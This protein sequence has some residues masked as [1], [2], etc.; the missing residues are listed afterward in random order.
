M[1]TSI[2]DA[3]RHFEDEERPERP[4]PPPFDPEAVA[5]PTR[6]PAARR[7]APEEIAA[8]Q[9]RLHDVLS[10]PEPGA[11]KV[12]AKGL[13]R[14]GMQMLMG[15][16]SAV[17]WFGDLIS[18]EDI[19]RGGYNFRK[20]WEERVR[21]GWSAP[22]P[23]I[24]KGT[25]GEN[26]SVKRALGIISEGVGSLG[27]A[28][29]A[30]VV[31][32]Q[33]WA[34]PVLLGVTETAGQYEEARAKGRDF[35]DASGLF[36]IAAGGTIWLESLPIGRM[37]KGF[38]KF[39]GRFP[40]G[41]TK[42][43]VGT[44][45]QE[46][47]QE[48]AQQLLQNAVAKYGYDDTRSLMEGMA[49]ATIGGFGAGGIAGGTIGRLQ[50]FAEKHG[51]KEG[52][53]ED[54]ER[55]KGAMERE[56]VAVADHM[57]GEPDTGSVVSRLAD[58]F[59]QGHLPTEA[60]IAQRGDLEV[61]QLVTTPKGQG[62]INEID[63][64]YVAVQLHGQTEPEGF[65]DEVIMP[66]E[67]IFPG[68]GEEQLEL[69]PEP[70]PTEEAAREM[71]E[72]E[73]K[74]AK[75]E[76]IGYVRWDEDQQVW[77]WGNRRLGVEG[78]VPL[79]QFKDHP[80]LGTAKQQAKL[81]ARAL[82]TT[83]YHEPRKE[84]AKPVPKPAEPG[85]KVEADK[86]EPQRTAG[87]RND[88]FFSGEWAT[89]QLETIEQ[90]KH[91][92]E[93]AAVNTEA[94]LKS[95][96]YD[97]TYPVPEQGGIL[98]ARRT[99]KYKTDEAYRNKVE[100]VIQD[101]AQVSLDAIK[102]RQI[103]TGQVN[104][105]LF[106]VAY[107]LED[108][109]Y[110]QTGKKSTA[111]AS[112]NVSRAWSQ[113][114]KNKYP[115]V[116]RLGDIS[117]REALQNSLDA[118]MRAKRTKKLVGQKGAIDIEV[119][120]REPIPATPGADIALAN[121]F[122][123]LAQEKG[124]TLSVDEAYVQLTDMAKYGSASKHA[125][126]MKPP[127]EYLGVTMQ[128]VKEA[129]GEG[130]T[131]S[132]SGFSVDD[133]GIGMSSTDIDTKLLDLHGTGKDVEGEF[134]GFG[135][136]GAVIFGPHKSARWAL[137]T[138]DNY[139]T[140]QMA[141][142]EEEVGTTELRQGTRI[143]VRTDTAIVHSR[144]ARMY[145]E[146]TRPPTGVKIRYR[147]QWDGSLR[148]L[149]DPFKGRRKKSHHIVQDENTEMEVSYYPKPHEDYERMMVIRLVG[150]TA[151]TK[152]TQAIRKVEDEGFR[153]ALVIDITTKVTPSHLDYP[154]DA[155]RMNFKSGVPQEAVTK[156]INR[157]TTDKASAARVGVLHTWH[158][159][160]A[161]R[162]WKDTL[163]K[164][165]T[166]KRY[167]ALLKVIDEIYQETNQWYGRGPAI[168]DSP[169]T[170]L[171]LMR[172]KID[173]GV[174]NRGGSQLHA[175]FLTA[176]EAAAWILAEPLGNPNP[177][178]Y[179]L[180]SKKKD[181]K[182]VGAEYAALTG[183]MG[184]NFRTQLDKT[185]LKSPNDFAHFLKSL[186]AHEYAHLE[187][188]PHDEMFS[189]AREH[190]DRLAA[191]HFN[192]LLRISE[193]MIGRDS[194]MRTKVIVKKEV[195]HVVERVIEEERVVE[196]RIETIVAD[197][198]QMELFQ[199]HELGG[200]GGSEAEIYLH[201]QS[202]RQLQLFASGNDR[203]A[204]GWGS[205][206]RTLEP[207]GGIQQPS[208]QGA[209]RPS[210]GRLRHRRHDATASGV[211][212]ADFP[213]I[214]FGPPEQRTL[215]RRVRNWITP[216]TAAQRRRI[217]EAPEYP[218]QMSPPW[219]RALKNTPQYSIQRVE[220]PVVTHY[221]KK[222][223]EPVTT[224][225]V[226][227][228][229]IPDHIDAQLTDGKP[230]ILFNTLEDA[231]NHNINPTRLKDWLELYDANIK[232]KKGGDF[233][234]RPNDGKLQDV[235]IL[236]LT[237]GC[238]RVPTILERVHVGVMPANTRLESCYEGMCFVNYKRYTLYGKV[239][240]MEIRDLAMAD[241][242]ALDGWLKRANIAKLNDTPFIREGSAGDSSHAFATEAA[243]SWLHHSRERGID[244]P[245]VF[246]SSGYAPVTDN[247]Y[248]RLTP[249]ADRFVAHFS[250]SGWFERNE[251]MMRLAEFQAAKNAGIPA[252]LRVITNRDQ[253]MNRYGKLVDMSYNEEFLLNRMGDM[254]LMQ[255]E[256]LET[257]YHNDSPG[258]SRRDPNHR[259]TASGEFEN[260][261]AETGQCV[262]CGAKCQVNKLIGGRHGK[263]RI[264]VP[265]QYSLERG[266]PPAG[267]VQS[268][269]H[270]GATKGSE[271]DTWR[272]QVVAQD[273]IDQGIEIGEGIEQDYIDLGEGRDYLREA[274]AAADVTILHWIPDEI[275]KVGV[276][277]EF[278]I[279]DIHSIE[280]WREALLKSDSSYIYVFGG[281]DE[282]SAKKLGELPG[283]TMEVAGPRWAEVVR[284]TRNVPQYQMIDAR[285]RFINRRANSIRT[286][287][288]QW[289]EGV[290]VEEQR[291]AEVQRE[292]T[293]FLIKHDIGI[294]FFEEFAEFPEN[295]GLSEEEVV[296]AYRRRFG[297]M[298]H[299]GVG[300]ARISIGS[301]LT[302]T[303]DIKIENM[304][305]RLKRQS[306]TMGGWVAVEDGGKLFKTGVAVSMNYAHVQ[307]PYKKTAMGDLIIKADVRDRQAEGELP[308]IEPFGVY[309]QHDTGQLV[310]EDLR[311][312]IITL[313]SPLVIKF[314]VVPGEAAYDQNN[315]KALLSQAYGDMTGHD[316]RE[317]LLAEGF[318][319]VVAVGQTLQGRPMGVKE[320]VYLGPQ[321]HY[322]RSPAEEARPREK[323]LARVTVEDLQTLFPKQRLGINEQGDITVET[324]RGDVLRIQGVEEITPDE[325]ALNIAYGQAGLKGGERILGE[326][327]RGRIRLQRDA[328][329]R[330]TLA[331]ESMHWLEDVGIL[332]ANDVGI[333]RGTIK[334]LYREGKFDPVRDRDGNI[335]D[336][337][338]SE[339]RANYLASQIYA[340][341]S[342]VMAKIVK[343]IEEF[344]DRLVNL[345]A[346]TS[347]AV[348]RDVKTGMIYE[349]GMAGGHGVQIH[350]PA[351][352]SGPI[353]T[354]QLKNWVISV[355][356]NRATPQE[357][358]KTLQSAKKKPQNFKEEELKWSG[359]IEWL[360]DMQEE[361][362]PLFQGGR[363][364]KEQIVQWLS[365]HNIKLI[366]NPMVTSHEERRLVMHGEP[367]AF[368]PE[369]LDEFDIY[370]V[371]DTWHVEFNELGTPWGDWEDINPQELREMQGQPGVPILHE[372]Q[373][374]ALEHWQRT[375]EVF[376]ASHLESSPLVPVPF[377]WFADTP[378]G[379]FQI[380][381]RVHYNDELEIERAEYVLFKDGSELWRDETYN[382]YSEDEL[383][384]LLTSMVDE[385]D[386]NLQ[387][388]FH[389]TADVEAGGA[390][391]QTHVTP[392]SYENYQE[393]LLEMPTLLEGAEES[394]EDARQDYADFV[395]EMLEKYPGVDFMDSRAAEDVDGQR[396]GLEM[397]EP[398]QA[399]T[400][401]QID[402][403]RMLELN[404]RVA[405]AQARMEA[406]TFT[407]YHWQGEKNFV[408]HVRFNE[409][410]TE[411]GR[412]LL[413][414]EE[415]QS[416]WHGDARKMRI[417]QVNK[418]IR[419]QGMTR[420]EAEAKVP[421]DYGYVPPDIGPLMRE[422]REKLKYRSHVL[423]QKWGMAPKGDTHYFHYPTEMRD[424]IE[425]RSVEQGRSQEGQQ[426]IDAFMELWRE[427][428]WLKK[429][430]EHGNPMA[431]FRSSYPLL[432]MKRMIRWAA[433]NGYDMVGWTPGWIQVDRW[434]RTLRQHLDQI[435]WTHQYAPDWTPA[436]HWTN[437]LSRMIHAPVAKWWAEFLEQPNLVNQLRELLGGDFR[438][439]SLAKDLNQLT[440]GERISV[441]QAYLYE[442]PDGAATIQALIP[443]F[444]AMHGEISE[445]LRE[446]GAAR[447]PEERLKRIELIEEGEDVG[448]YYPYEFDLQYRVTALLN[449]IEKWQ[450]PIIE[451][452]NYPS[453][454]IPPDGPA[455]PPAAFMNSA[456]RENQRHKLWQSA[457]G[458]LFAYLNFMNMDSND[459]LSFTGY[460]QHYTGEAMDIK[461][462]N[463]VRV[464]G[465]KEGN[466]KVNKVWHLTDEF[467][468]EG[469][470]TSLEGLVGPDVYQ[471]ILK[472]EEGSV[473]GDD[474]T[475]GGEQFKA[476]YD[477]MVRTMTERFITHKTKGWDSK[478]V[479]TIQFEG[480]YVQTHKYNG[481]EYDAAQLRDIYEEYKYDAS[482]STALHNIV[483]H[484]GQG[485]SFQSAMDEYGTVAVASILG[486]NIQ[487]GEFEMVEV[488]AFDVTPKMAEDAMQGFPQFQLVR[489]YEYPDFIKEKF[490]VESE[491]MIERIKKTV[492]NFRKNWR[493]MAL[494]RLSP[495]LEHLGEQPYMLHRLETGIPAALSMLMRHG[496]LEWDGLAMTV[497]T[498]D[499][500]FLS[501][502]E[503]LQGDDAH[504]LLYW[505]AAKRAAYLDQFPDE[506][507]SAEEGATLEKW[508]DRDTRAQILEWAGEPSTP[509]QTWESLN[510]ELQEW[511]KSILD[512]AE[513]SGLI[514]PMVREEWEQ[515]Y[516]LPFFRVMEDP[517]MRDKILGGPQQ[518][519]R[520]ISAQIFKLYGA[521]MEI[522]NPFENLIRMWTHLIHESQRNT[523]RSVAFYEAQKKALGG[524]T[525]VLEEVSFAD[526]HRFYSAPRKEGQ[527]GRMTFVT[528]DSKEPVLAFLS[529]GRRVYF[530]VN[531]PALYEAMSNINA[532]RFEGYLMD[533][534]RGAKRLL[535]GAATFSPGFRIRNMFRDTLHVALVS[536]SFTPFLD[537]AKGFAK[538][539][540]EDEDYIKFMASMGGF[541]SSYVN[542][543][544][545][546]A[547]A[548]YVQRIIDKEG[549]GAEAR[550]LDSGKKILNF[551]QK[552][553]AASENAA[554]VQLYANL[555]GQNVSHLQAAFQGRD[556]LDFTMR[557]DAAAFQLAIATVPF[558]NARAQGL[559]KLGRA[560]KEDPQA[561][562]RKGFMLTMASMILWWFN[563]DKEEYK[564]LEDWDKWQ[565]Y[566]FWLGNE[567]YRL[568]KPFEVGAVFSSLFES[569]ADVMAGDEELEFMWEWL[570]HTAQ[571]NLNL[572]DLPALLKPA[573]EQWGNKVFYTGRKI[574]PQRLEPLPPGAQAEPWTP[575]FLQYLGRKFNISPRRAEALARGYLASYA[576]GFFVMSDWALRAM[577]DWPEKPR[578]VWEEVPTIGS[579]I[580]RKGP[581]RRTKYET[582][583]YELFREVDEIYNLATHYRRSGDMEAAKAVVAADKARLQWRKP[584]LEV[585]K[586]ARL[587]SG[588]IRY[589]M[590][591]DMS[592]DM[593]RKEI[594]NLSQMR[595][596]LM[597]KIY[598]LYMEGH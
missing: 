235:T 577:Q 275:G 415:I 294:P 335:V 535:T 588:R 184:F 453:T 301:K 473:E 148:E 51:N 245:T 367:Q 23:R 471:K 120:G 352:K 345:V 269:A 145:V 236:V 203:L 593:K 592:A 26:P 594:D 280:Q 96:F 198:D 432:A 393:L 418:L 443:D 242:A 512:L 32:G 201:P 356:P 287:L 417:R 548:R 273:L 71:E 562:F 576:Q 579:F 7:Y 291:L 565:Y 97:E 154:L 511:N 62:V 230:E 67:G 330:F 516:Y 66:V 457:P 364:A 470:L 555:R 299:L 156:I 125:E 234:Q 355:G 61:G 118:V 479:G 595:N 431:P 130:K 455:P 101:M 317:T 155:S 191:P 313:R 57:E 426:D 256:I 394:V 531:D 247:R 195:R 371:G 404:L 585:K 491:G 390:R 42:G 586:R 302:Q 515:H 369:T 142:A 407:H 188:S 297:K 21:E 279:S 147:D 397:H 501:W 507:R 368:L 560:A 298:R 360:E 380:E 388:D 141:N 337:G 572:I 309:M 238:Q 399:R 257:P 478:G 282:V 474:L 50:A 110:V 135:I 20:Y 227:L 92:V 187:A 108:M 265:A 83:E 54:I 109:E 549:K 241:P 370:L 550:I 400:I 421:Q 196:E 84:A 114:A 401:S 328:A 539:M 375:R 414:I 385:A 517:Q 382:V 570:K 249:Y 36:A 430:K 93:H 223:E 441:L 159:L 425:D 136:A 224:A 524:D 268:I 233:W 217:T 379:N 536:G 277:G 69:F 462:N 138:R 176:Y 420:E 216:R 89:R 64:D 29:T 63:K 315:W 598:R 122:Y 384:R 495:V 206:E 149:D 372:D 571:D 502:L 322:Y 53:E 212:E 505:V 487:F 306:Q 91:D 131:P 410:L 321:P 105:G 90:R 232:L 350:A 151:K 569:A 497:R 413:Y 215:W 186:V 363:L 354:S 509:G 439:M 503:G 166:N 568:P 411:D 334:R 468:V 488:P 374:M 160:A 128:E 283:Y 541:G 538:A 574:T 189:I 324:K 121:R 41:F 406:Q 58:E 289:S 456:A 211:G 422:A 508:L 75:K 333:L 476:Y 143:E 40:T 213:D 323:G 129:F 24:F 362:L 459:R 175:L 137:H 319:S 171:E 205:T 19:S 433:E 499:K 346:R 564:E 56:T 442:N 290:G 251:I 529:G 68:V 87:L 218:D 39:G 161:R 582:R 17:R 480:R 85:I 543:D 79:T 106:G 383:N 554:R 103:L 226:F 477:R 472:E 366:D 310:G 434:S 440:P 339:D 349:Q 210:E 451:E 316:L 15:T 2:E 77:R 575:L 587:I 293:N 250:V 27:L 589:I 221:T 272:I 10:K 202:A 435:K 318:D 342:G 111:K 348:V 276:V 552:I 47:L 485:Y 76:G 580:K 284:Y 139:F 52:F 113:E 104:S 597:K 556:L 493:Q 162:E 237:K 119:I 332:T 498:K 244:V 326:Y 34:A 174:K 14:S 80:T 357:W 35:W 386:E 486:G 258:I 263:S 429:R 583:F 46:M 48:D 199:E 271:N 447:A 402:R 74:E 489:R 239:E 222:G 264:Y 132:Y 344:I 112:V 153:G 115:Y 16:G 545:P 123:K 365:A 228:V 553:G 405:D 510:N 347:G 266:K 270:V 331:H 126:T 563:R 8:E 305:D 173:K 450:V 395:D 225:R 559:F 521:E 526:V 140:D 469:N 454:E 300:E 94:F 25:W 448:K 12:I 377:Q 59:D 403:D 504:K 312:G 86:V 82:A 194:K 185:S 314:N 338:G 427:W 197:P 43:M 465:L 533:A 358:I 353:W 5:E 214:F 260:I 262:S 591:S 522:G 152:L 169:I 252:V 467:A 88:P 144:I 209:T 520:F 525:P 164:L 566:H 6:E 409:R 38:K 296:H 542:A 180:L 229:S 248:G 423:A 490:N 494:D 31:T 343:K 519:R 561:F 208:P 392:G 419:E 168:G 438:V 179:G 547:L 231:R 412:R 540:R 278:E 220:A 584:M 373:I 381:R 1:P 285:E 11:T 341:P 22:D 55:L 78:E 259:S 73:K 387:S 253:L 327:N 464:Q 254:G 463:M 567:H 551:W 288:E 124:G 530:K 267:T 546:K 537:T 181:G 70:E 182:R 325:Y 398:M 573:F 177:K 4:A 460:W 95:E 72:E 246:I 444:S 33:P 60:E 107:S 496:K 286:K 428:D 436:M 190:K 437:D 49:E 240:N 581:A 193:A 518:N 165:G 134:G 590:Y 146:S 178:L 449:M 28:I 596:D 336:L 167:Q 116:W 207:G 458:R 311:R 307:G 446:A 578:M 37:L 482:V 484:M 255:M 396:M 163:K 100:S 481:P 320:V 98:A 18:N 483:F 544:D 170:P 424:A 475:I 274:P 3:L 557:G 157:L 534:F 219:R 44:G 172:I 9:F 408:V 500:G 506:R 295:Q 528:K 308:E 261:C 329:N 445:Q 378:I 13:L 133:N 514:N 492:E 304:Y 532:A 527:R 150:K 243:E 292:A 65:R 513:D 183:E 416:D 452:P 117:I 204:T 102:K 389:Y 158:N 461:P 351:Q 466:E 391:H 376:T 127:M 45:V 361:T 340:E 281:I 523:A 359:I 81:A 303:R 192:Q 99:E 30:S 558:M 200:Y